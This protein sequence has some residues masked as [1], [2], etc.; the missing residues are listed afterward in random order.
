MM[1]EN[2]R[3][4]NRITGARVLA[5]VGFDRHEI[6][7]SSYKKAKAHGEK[8]QG[9]NTERRILSYLT[10][11]DREIEEHGSPLEQRLWRASSNKDDLLVKEENITDSSWDLL[12]Q[13]LNAHNSEKV[14]LTDDLKHEY[15]EKWRKLQKESL[16]KWATFLANENSPFPLWFKIYAWDGMAKM[17]AYNKEKRKYESRN[18][19]TTAPYPDPDAEVLSGVFDIVNRYHGNN[20]REFFTAEGARRI[21]LEEMVKSGNFSK[22]FN[23]VQQDLVPVLEPPENTKDIH[24]EWLE[25]GVEDVDELVRSSRGTGWCITS[26]AVCKNYFKYGT[27]YDKGGRFSD[28]NG[29]KFYLFHLKDPTSDNLVKNGCASIRLDP[30]G[31]VAE[32]SGLKKGQALHDSLIPIVEEKVKTLPGSE[33]FL[34]KLADKKHLADLENK[35][36]SGNELSKDDL[37]FL[38]EVHR[39]IETLDSYFLRDP[40]IYK[41]KNDYDLKHVLEVG[42][43]PNLIVQKISPEKTAEELYVLLGHG[44]NIDSIISKL[45]PVFI[46]ENLEFLLESGANANRIIYKLDP[47]QLTEDQ[48]SILEK[49]GASRGSVIAKLKGSIFNVFKSNK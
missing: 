3:H 20:E 41:L 19:T 22:I 30:D 2:Q 40:R 34:T 23:A 31:R 16:D 25:Y 6:V 43:D 33:A 12:I 36:N 21:E 14:E 5:L 18:N 1:E 15:C 45:D 11:L 39:P 27:H 9:K 49:Y 17:G 10:R 38:F 7:D 42:I 35:I 46:S 13:E 28:Q 37:E 24:G 4:Q 47:D 44:A 26:A 32:I 29:A 8:L 48:K